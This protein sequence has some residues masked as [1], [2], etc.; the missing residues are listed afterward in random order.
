MSTRSAPKGQGRRSH[1][2]SATVSQVVSHIVYQE[3][4]DT[5]RDSFS[6]TGTNLYVGSS[7]GQVWWYTLDYN[8]PSSS[9]NSVSI[10][11]FV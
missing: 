8:S 7:D 10:H 2:R 5:R 11:G 4:D 6:I 1:V 9:S 3:A